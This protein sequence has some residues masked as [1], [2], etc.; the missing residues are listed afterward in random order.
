METESEGHLPFIYIDIAS[1]FFKR[2]RVTP[3]DVKL[4]SA[5]A[6]TSDNGGRPFSAASVEG[7]CRVMKTYYE[8]QQ[9]VRCR[10]RCFQRVSSE[11]SQA[12]KA[13]L[14]SVGNEG[15]FS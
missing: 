13:E 12:I 3:H 2:A 4:Y 11:C 1:N 15:E 8:T 7:L 9:Y 6:V 10:K 5:C 14:V